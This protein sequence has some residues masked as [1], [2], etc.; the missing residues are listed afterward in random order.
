MDDG[1]SRTHTTRFGWCSQDVLAQLSKLDPD[2][3][4]R[5]AAVDLVTSNFDKFGDNG[6]VRL[7][8]SDPIPYRAPYYVPVLFTRSLFRVS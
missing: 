3:P 8:S 6:E 1:L 5:P 4:R 7:V 2:D